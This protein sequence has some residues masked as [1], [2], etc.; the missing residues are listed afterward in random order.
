MSHTIS[1][2]VLKRILRYMRCEPVSRVCDGAVA[3]VLY[4]RRR[5]PGDAACLTSCLREMNQAP[6]QGGTAFARPNDRAPPECGGN[7]SDLSM[8][9]EHTKHEQ[10]PGAK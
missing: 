7:D 1:R 9:A 3:G 10:Q 8:H 4:K 5:G 2:Y 6:W